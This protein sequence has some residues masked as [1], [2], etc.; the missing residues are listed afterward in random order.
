MGKRKRPRGRGTIDQRIA[1]AVLKIKCENPEHD[2]CGFPVLVCRE[3]QSPSTTPETSLGVLL[4][5]FGWYCHQCSMSDRQELRTF[6]GRLRNIR[7]SS[8]KVAKNSAKRAK[9]ERK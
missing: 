9:K 5:R 3:C 6:F 8:T 1:T 2:A 4:E 7:D